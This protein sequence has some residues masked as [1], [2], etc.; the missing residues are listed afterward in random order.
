MFAHNLSAGAAFG[1]P[2]SKHNDN[3]PVLGDSAEN[4][5]ADGVNLQA[6][7]APTKLA[8]RCGISLADQIHPKCLSDVGSNLLHVKVD[9]MFG[10]TFLDFFQS[11]ND[12]TYNNRCFNKGVGRNY[13]DWFLPLGFR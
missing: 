9:P 1:D 11:A 10:S 7:S 4:E 8:G 13:K 5:L 12:E 3:F 2:R 6:F